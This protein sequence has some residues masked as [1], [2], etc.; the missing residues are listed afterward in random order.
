MDR[1]SAFSPHT[2]LETYYPAF[3]N[4]RGKKAVVVGGGRVAERKILALLRA[5][6]DV[7]V[8]SPDITNKLEKEKTN[9]NLRHIGRRYRK[10]DLDN[11]FLAIAATDSV[12]TNERVSRDAPCLVNV[13]DTPKLCNFFVP[14][15]VNRGHLTIAISTGG[16][17][18]AL[19]KSIRKEIEKEFGSEIT[20][21]LTVVRKIRAEAIRTI[22]DNKKRSRFLKAIA[23]DKMLRLLR[24]RGL[25]EAKRRV[26]DLFRKAQFS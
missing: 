3:L 15:T 9:R 7:T 18:P 13:V 6:A 4:L 14:S 16:V 24:E 26:Y 1:K 20:R 5:G 19:S 11:A 12:I 23:S 25:G 21:Y 8:V 10:G 17:S 22:S 2:A